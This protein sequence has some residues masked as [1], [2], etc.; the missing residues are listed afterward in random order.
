MLLCIYSKEK[1]SGKE[2]KK[3]FINESVL[4][5]E[6]KVD[7]GKVLYFKVVRDK[8]Y[9]S[10]KSKNGY[11][12]ITFSSN[13][14]ESDILPWVYIGTRYWRQKKCLAFLLLKPQFQVPLQGAAGY[15]NAIGTINNVC[16]L[17]KIKGMFDVSNVSMQETIELFGLPSIKED[18]YQKFFTYDIGDYSPESFLRGEFEK[19]GKVESAYTSWAYYL[20]DESGLLPEE[21][22]WISSFSKNII[23]QSEI[24]FCIG[25]CIDEAISPY[26]SLFFNNG[27]EKLGCFGVRPIAY[28]PIESQE[29]KKYS[30]LTEIIQDKMKLYGIGVRAF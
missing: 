3:M 11:R 2:R 19:E 24:H 1:T 18:L 10:P 4:L 22:Y 20:Q 29:E 23:S 7:V 8:S 13:Q 5:G 14:I 21:P 25:A 30:S 6:N 28:M 9:F 26:Y 17:L 15:V 16:N 27:E 12:D